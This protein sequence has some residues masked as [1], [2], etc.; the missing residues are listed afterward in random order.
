MILERIVL[1]FMALLGSPI[2]NTL[3]NPRYFSTISPEQ[4]QSLINSVDDGRKMIILDVR[5][6]AEFSH[7][8][9]KGAILVDLFS[10]H[11]SDKIG[12]LDKKENHL[13]YC[14]SGRRSAR[15]MALMK[16]SGFERVYNLKGGI[17]LWQAKKLP[18]EKPVSNE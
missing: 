10:A 9:I 3:D 15:A 16:N 14:R 4:A 8:F 17:L 7:G 12:K 13:V 2:D 11:F 18:I 5:S 1:T 6:P